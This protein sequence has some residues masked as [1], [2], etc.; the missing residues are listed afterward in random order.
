MTAEMI[1]IIIYGACILAMLAILIFHKSQLKFWQKVLTV[2][3]APLM[4]VILIIG[5]IVIAIDHV[6]KHGFHDILP[7]R[8]S[9]AYPLDEADFKVWP[10]DTVQCGDEK[11][12]ITEYNKRF[13]K[14]LTLD[15]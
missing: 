3:L 14:Q 8:K 15:H 7:R 4:I 12:C 2:L 9:K 5:F 6:I 10:K 13:G 1:Y 11:M